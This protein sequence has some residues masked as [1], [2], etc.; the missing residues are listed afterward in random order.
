MYVLSYNLC[1]NCINP[2]NN[3]SQ[4]LPSF[5]NK[6]QKE[7][8]KSTCLKNVADFI[9][10]SETRIAYSF[11]ALQECPGWINILNLLPHHKDSLKYIHH[12]FNRIEMVT[13]YNKKL[14]TLLAVSVGKF[15]NDNGR[16]FQVLILEKKDDLNIYIFIN[17]HAPHNYS[18]INLERD[19]SNSIYHGSKINYQPGG[20][21]NVQDLPKNEN[22][23]PKYLNNT[24]VRMIVAGDFN[25]HGNN[26]WKGLKP[27]KFINNN[28]KGSLNTVKVRMTR[29]PPLTC[30]TGKYKLR[31]SIDDDK[32]YGDYILIN[33]LLNYD[34]VSES[35]IPRKYYKYANAEI[36]PKSDHLPI[37][38][39]ISSK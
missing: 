10:I 32:L 13:F 15:N 29:K 2:S 25:D 28:I 9:D 21:M 1:W 8:G 24:K 34:D 38:A 36:H 11:I 12:K 16:P 39:K 30:C 4:S 23:F 3:S 20:Y 26:F 31:E 37:K 22:I 14:F 6:L 35:Y 18:K 7:T 33:N 19:L 27:F 5:C 17:L